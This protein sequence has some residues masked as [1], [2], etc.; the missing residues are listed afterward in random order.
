MNSSE[1]I[2]NTSEIDEISKENENN[3]LLNKNEFIDE[4]DSESDIN[5]DEKLLIEKLLEDNFKI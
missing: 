5:D 4:E 1:D 2:T 3:K